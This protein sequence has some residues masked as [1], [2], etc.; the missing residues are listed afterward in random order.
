MPKV[1]A[2]KTPEKRASQKVV[3][4]VAEGDEKSLSSL[5]SMTSL[6]LTT[7]SIKKEP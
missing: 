7:L 2:K 5:I 6:L 4:E 3:E 1:K